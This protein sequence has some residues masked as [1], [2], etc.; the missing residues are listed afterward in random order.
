MATAS[1]FT[2]MMDRCRPETAA[3]DYTVQAS[4]VVLATGGASALSGYS[5][6]AI[7]YSLHFSGSAALSLL[8]LLAVA[9]LVGRD[10]H[11]RELRA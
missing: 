10:G 11:P 7:G 9:V 1:L 5:A 3:T 6:Q 8:A 2:W 4:A